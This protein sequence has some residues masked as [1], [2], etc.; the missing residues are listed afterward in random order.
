MKIKEVEERV[1][2]SAKNIR[3]YEKEGLIKPGRN[4]ENKYRNFSEAD[5]ERLEQIK[6][7]RK[8]GISLEIMR[9]V[10]TDEL[11]LSDC[12]D[13]RRAELEEEQ[14]YLKELYEMC[15]VLCRTRPS[16][17]TLSKAGYLEEIQ[18]KER[19]G[20]RF[21][22]IVNDYITRARNIVIDPAFCFEPSEPILNGKDF[23]KELVLYCEAKG[24]SLDIRHEGMEPVVYI[25]GKKYLC[26]LEQPRMIELKGLLRILLPFYIVNTYGF[27][28]VYAYPYQ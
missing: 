23:T 9:K 24:K 11:R 6:L 13:I 25:D 2:L 3:F 5:V 12:L 8:L 26:M 17:E 1:G 14:N 28:F 20:C 15:D 18:M 27:R 7:L 19:Q 4:K 10:F 21:I 22:D 16:L